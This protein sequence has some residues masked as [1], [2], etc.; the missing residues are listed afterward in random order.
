MPKLDPYT[1]PRARRTAETRTF[2]LDGE[3]HP[4]TLTLWDRLLGPGEAA[5][6]EEAAQLEETYI[7]GGPARGPAP[8]PDPDF[9]P[10]R[11]MFRIICRLKRLQCP[12]DPADAY[13]T[14]ELCF[15]SVRQPRNFEAVV[16]WANR[17]ET[18]DTP[19]EA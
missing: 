10:A 12:E 19:G 8:F 5:A 3:E 16:E 6:I 15:L 4:L 17:R 18:G 9:E 13:D 11:S 7:T 1:L 14:M 2:T